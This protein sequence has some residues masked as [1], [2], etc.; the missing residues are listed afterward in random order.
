MLKRYLSHKI[1]GLNRWLQHPERPDDVTLESDAQEKMARYENIADEVKAL[2]SL[3]TL[4]VL[5]LLQYGVRLEFLEIGVTVAA[6]FESGGGKNEIFVIDSDGQRKHR[7]VFSKLGI[8]TLINTIEED[9]FSALKAE[10][11]SAAMASQ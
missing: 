8:D 3:R 10:D 5:A 11:A 2:R 9:L 6:D 7:V 1:R 4:G